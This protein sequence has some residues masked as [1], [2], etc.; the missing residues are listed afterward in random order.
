MNWIK[1]VEA[2]YGQPIEQILMAERQAA[3]VTGTSLPMLADEFGVKRHQL[4]DFCAKIGIRWPRIY[5]QVQRDACARKLGM[6]KQERCPKYNV[7][8]KM[9]SI[10]EMAKMAG[11]S[12]DGMRH[13]L[14]RGMSPE[15]AVS[16]PRVSH[17]ERGLRAAA[18]R[19]GREKRTGIQR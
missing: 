11:M 9:M 6:T 13:R 4:H 7:F 16:E 17:R 12:H 10:P 3:S 8:G 1:R 15:A 19:Y 2:E 5:S 14:S 18:T